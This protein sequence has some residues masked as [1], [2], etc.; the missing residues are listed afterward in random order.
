MRCEE[1]T[2]S[3]KLFFHFRTE[4]SLDTP[5][6]KIEQASPKLV[7]PPIYYRDKNRLSSHSM[8]S[9][10]RNIM[11][12]GHANTLTSLQTPHIL[13]SLSKA[14]ST[15]ANALPGVESVSR[16]QAQQQQSQL[17]QQQPPSPQLYHHNISAHVVSPFDSQ[18]HNV[19]STVASK[20]H[21]P[22]VPS[23]ASNSFTDNSSCFT[24][25]IPS[26]EIQVESPKNMTVVEPMKYYPYKE[27][28]KPFEMSDF[29]KYSTKFRQKTASAN[30]MQSENSS[31]QLPPKNVVHQAK[32]PHR[33]MHSMSLSANV[34]EPASPYQ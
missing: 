4:T 1:K 30:I 16:G 15:S 7:S 13:S 8:H 5:V 6:R 25:N 24:P 22:N 11:S 31:P 19:P 12:V 23:S 17:L 18:N 29:Y 33:H 27:Q 26:A 9:P 20:L 32:N 10:N 14:L 2:Q 3:N 28:I 34:A 21:S